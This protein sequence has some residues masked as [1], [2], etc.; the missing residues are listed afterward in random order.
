MS[1]NDRIARLFRLAEILAGSA[2][3]LPLAR[4]A[5][6]EG[7]K[8]RSVY[9][10]IEALELAGFPV[11]VEDN[12]YRL[13]ESFAPAAKLGIDSEELLALHLAAQQAAGW[14]SGAASGGPSAVAGAP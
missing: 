1:R 7:W 14:A 2:R 3:G 11:V 10:D 9:R 13:L 6:K 5:A 12:R 4:I 8:V